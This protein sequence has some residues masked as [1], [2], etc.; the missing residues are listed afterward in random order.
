[1]PRA[2]ASSTKRRCCAC[3]TKGHL[4]GAALD[5]FATEPLARRLAVA[6]APQAH[7]HAAPRR[8]RRAKHNRPVSTILARQVIDFVATGASRAAVNLP[9]LTAGS[10]ARGRPRGCR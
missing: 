6:R 7:P 1:M 4:G 8:S 3:S 5:T 10:R 9:P 2:A